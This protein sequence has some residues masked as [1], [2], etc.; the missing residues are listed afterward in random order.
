MPKGV[1]ELYV[2]K[3][4]LALQLPETPTIYNT[5]VTANEWTEI[6][7]GLT[8]TAVWLLYNRNRRKI[9]YAF[10]DNPSTY[11]TLEKDSVLIE[12]TALTQIYVRSTQADTIELE[13]WQFVK[14]E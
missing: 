9:E 6:A 4:L 2:L 3:D 14:E 13:V 7:T 12:D 11:R 1:E 10:E 5:S 8:N